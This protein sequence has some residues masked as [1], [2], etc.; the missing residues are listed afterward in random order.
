MKF[1]YG[2][3]Y[4]RPPTPPEKDWDNDFINMGRAN[5]NIVKFWAVWRWHNPAYGIYRWDDL[6]K[7]MD[8][9]KK[10]GM[11]VIL[12]VI[13]DS[14]PA[15]FIK[16]HP[17]SRAVTASGQV[18]Q[19]YASASRQTG[20]ANSV[21][22]Q[23][24][25]YMEA[26]AKFLENV[27]KRYRKHPAL[28][29]WDL[30]NE[31]WLPYK[32]FMNG[33]AEDSVCYC[34]HTK[35]KFILWLRKKYGKIE[36]LNKCWARNYSDFSETELP[37]RSETFTD[38]CDFRTFMMHTLTEELK[39]RAGI[40][41]KFDPGR[42]IM[43][44]AGFSSI[45]TDPVFIGNDDW[46]L[47]EQVDIYG[48][49]LGGLWREGW[50][51]NKPASSYE[52]IPIEADALRCSAE[53]KEIWASEFHAYSG[54]AFQALDPDVEKKHIQRWIAELIGCGLNKSLLFWQYRTELLGAE[55]PAW[56]ITG[57][58]GNGGRKYEDAQDTGESFS[59]YGEKIALA[60][61]PKNE[62]AIVYNPDS[63]F[64]SWLG[65]TIDT[66]KS[67]RGFYRALYSNSLGC[68][69][70]HYYKTREKIF[71][72]KAV[73]LP[74]S[75]LIDRGFS[76]LLASYVNRGGILISEAQLGS[77]Q[78]ENGMHSAHVPGYGLEKLFGC[79]ETGLEY[80]DEK[81]SIKTSEGTVISGY[82][83]IEALNPSKGSILG[84]FEK[85]RPVI[86]SNKS[87]KGKT[88]YFGSFIG[89]GTIEYDSDENMKY[90][91]SLLGKE[92]IGKTFSFETTGKV[93]G[94]ILKGKG[95]DIFIF[96]NCENSENK[97]NVKEIS[98]YD[99][100]EDIYKRAALS[101]MNMTLEPLG[102]R[103]IIAYNK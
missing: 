89:Q 13:F 47:S 6:D 83:I 95:Y 71:D 75:F 103:M 88:F 17:D 42:R 72:Y 96:C 5:F 3:Q 36:N 24:P 8:L 50:Q 33:P 87:G 22:M 94:D 14:A 45:A 84:H 74:Y 65:G 53:G 25:S 9:A 11:H 97:V 46:E 63:Y 62:V 80:S 34:S 101:S 43:A 38:I 82:R 81:I 66:R 76:E 35:K 64:V 61:K 77:F 86:I 39:L 21:C 91:D 100:I 28:L 26:S 70:I 93:H 78:R 48:G 55:S 15:W 51:K 12:N 85:D 19:P 16:K 90:L 73:I 92:G 54:G 56:G 52:S 10:N 99:S 1:Y 102:C 32:T 49:S 4:Y 40:A 68:D 23:H 20:G 69:F 27:I 44:H 37:Y 2:A 41:R 59:K 79:E 60:E 58:D 7:L 31:P 29:V 57:L 67:I 98:K 30:W 18:L